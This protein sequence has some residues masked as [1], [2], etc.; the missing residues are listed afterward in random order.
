M[1]AAEKRSP[2]DTATLRD[3]Q[4]EG[5]HLLHDY[6]TVQNALMSPAAAEHCESIAS[7]VT[8]L[9]DRLQELLDRLEGSRGGQ[10]V[11][12]DDESTA[13]RS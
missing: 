4:D 8:R 10:V 2:T 9:T 1:S 13:V 5:D 3:L 11:R 7:T 6:R 12:A